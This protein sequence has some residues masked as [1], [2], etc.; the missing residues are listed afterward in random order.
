VTLPSPAP[1]VGALL[2]ALLTEPGR[3]RLTWYGPDGERVELSGAVL[4]NWVN[5][6]TNLLV[7][8]FDAA[9]GERVLLDLPGHWRSIVW[10]LAAWRAGAAVEVAEPGTP[11]PG[12]SADVVVTTDATRHPGADQPVVVTL[13]A[14]ALRSP[15]PLPSGAIDAASAVMTYGDAL[16]WVPPT[17]PAAVALTG[18]GPAL[19]HDALVAEALLDAEPGARTLVEATSLR[20]TL[21]AALGVLAADGS[22]VLVDPT[23][24]AGLGADAG[25]LTRLVETER[26]DANHL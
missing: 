9:P 10:G 11:E 6:T 25:R 8:E 2:S 21:L 18:A 22:L 17:D 5:K 3:P 26:V 14:L 1:S 23:T 15:A 20:A 13:A 16:G 7:E 12:A 4:V 24:A 19:T